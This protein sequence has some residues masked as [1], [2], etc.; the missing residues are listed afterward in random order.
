MAYQVPKKRFTFAG[1]RGSHVCSACHYW[2]PA[3][4]AP[5]GDGCRSL[6]PVPHMTVRCSWCK[7]QLTLDDGNFAS[8]ET[9]YLHVRCVKQFSL[10]HPGTPIDTGK[11]LSV[12]APEDP[13]NH[14]P[15]YTKHPSG[16]ECIEVTR[17][18]NFNR[19][20]AVKYVWRAGAKGDEIEDLKKAIW[21]LSD[22][23][24][25]LTAERKSDES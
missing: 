6:V 24:D 16:I 4:H 17:H 10:V 14:P 21:Y 22:E 11:G 20:N 1:A 15:H 9:G 8:T 18:M 7:F 23:V 2:V 12:P 25:R 5:G 19:G 13:V 3:A